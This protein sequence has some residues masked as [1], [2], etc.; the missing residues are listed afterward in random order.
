MDQTKRTETMKRT[1]RTIQIIVMVFIVLISTSV[2]AEDMEK[3]AQTGFQ[4]LSITSDARAAAMG[5]A[6]TTLSMGSSAL[7]FN[8]AMMTE[9]EGF[10]DMTA[11]QNQWIADIRHNAF[12]IAVKPGAGSWGVFGVSLQ[13]VDYGEVLGTV[14]D[15]SNPEGYQDIGNIEPTAL[16]IGLGYAKALSDRFSVGGQ[17]RWVKQDLGESIVPVDISEADTTVGKVL[18]ELMPLAFD[19]GTLFKTGIKSLAFGMSVRNFSKEIKYVDEGFQLP[20]VFTMGVSMNLMDLFETGESA[21]S[22]YLSMDATHYRSHSEQLIVGLDYRLN[23]LLSI[24]GGYVSSNDEDGINF[25]F[26]ISHFGLTFDYAYTPFGVFEK[27]QRMTVRFA[28]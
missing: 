25:G 6:V 4:F 15:A 22:L 7:F 14:V 21:Q 24:R 10:L 19:F 3:V 11:S 27:V 18:N 13:A 12:S 20:L 26:G 23:D 17:V 1:I 5:G 28:M 8:P 16:S 2:F 9:M